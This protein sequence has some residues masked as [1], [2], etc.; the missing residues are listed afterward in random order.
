MKKIAKAGLWMTMVQIMALVLAYIRQRGDYKPKASE[1]NMLKDACLALSGD[2]FFPETEKEV[3]M[4]G[5]TMK[6]VFNPYIL[7]GKS[8][9]VA[10]CCD[11]TDSTMMM[12]VDALFMKLSED[13]Q[14][15]VIAHEMGHI[16]YGHKAPTGYALRRLA[17]TALENAVQMMEQDADDYALETAFSNCLY[18]DKRKKAVKALTEVSMVVHG[19][20]AKKELLLRADRYR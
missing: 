11:S 8:M 2:L 9:A 10:M 16:H 19:K 14:K 4:G 13:A 15:F 17:L 12:V 18:V 5:Y 3:V 6:I 7:V 20:T 1:K